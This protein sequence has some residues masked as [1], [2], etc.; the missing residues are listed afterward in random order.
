MKKLVL[1]F[2][3][4]A[5]SSTATFAQSAPFFASDGF[6][7]FWNNPAA[8]ASF[9]SFSSNLIYQ[10]NWPAISGGFQTYAI[11]IEADTK[12][13][14]K[15]R[16]QK[17]NLPIGLNV[18]YQQEYGI[19]IQTINIP[20]SY[21]IKLKKST[22]AIGISAGLKRIMYH[23]NGPFYGD[24]NHYVDVSRFDLNAGLFWSG[25]NHYL[26]I[27]T[28][29]IAEPTYNTFKIYRHINFQAGYRFKVGQHYIYPMLNAVKRSGNSLFRAMTYIQ[30]KEDVF[31]LGAGISTYE[32]YYLGATVKVKQFKLAYLF[33]K[34]Y[35]TMGIYA[36]GS[37][38]FRLSYVISK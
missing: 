21:P 2:F 9:H 3:L 1:S 23:L 36:A 15:N 25:K 26:G 14:L 17:L 34:D 11:N 35:A 6:S 12:F 20:I 30:F 28:T 13:G 8:T 31:S 27:S 5:L 7:P 32:I 37:H 19:D 33:Y 22:L 4:L 24:P 38:E 16:K 10:N 18:I 29:N